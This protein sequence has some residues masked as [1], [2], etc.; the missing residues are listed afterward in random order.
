[1]VRKLG[2]THPVKRNFPMILWAESWVEVKVA[3]ILFVVALVVGLVRG[4]MRGVWRD[5]G[6]P[7]P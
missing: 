5:R 3:A 7:P 6:P 2:T 4:Y 1:M